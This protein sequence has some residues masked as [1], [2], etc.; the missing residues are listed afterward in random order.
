MKLFIVFSSN[1]LKNIKSTN[2]KRNIILGDVNS[3]LVKKPSLNSK[4]EKK[5]ILLIKNLFKNYKKNFLKNINKFINKFINHL[6][7]QLLLI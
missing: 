7:F 5:I 3:K 6:F 4:N 2:I 1:D